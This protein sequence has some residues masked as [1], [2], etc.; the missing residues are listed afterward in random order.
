MVVVGGLL[1]LPPPLL[2]GETDKLEKAAA[3]AAVRI[4]Q[5][6]K[7]HTSFPSIVRAHYLVA[8]EKVG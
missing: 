4:L 8:G 1:L 7:V 6:G 2:Q 3:A 5:W